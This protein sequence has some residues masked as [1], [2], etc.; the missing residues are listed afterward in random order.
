MTPT[1]LTTSVALNKLKRMSKPLKVIKTTDDLIEAFGKVAK[2]RGPTAAAAW[3]DVSLSAVSQ[4]KVTGVPPGYHYRM[5]HY[6]GGYGYAI[7]G[8][9]L[10]WV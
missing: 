4:W 9:R 5:A 6:L 10:G 3:A 2:R 8:Q 7:D 1:V